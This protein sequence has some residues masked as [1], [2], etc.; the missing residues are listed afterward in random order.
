MN[1]HI[2]HLPAIACRVSVQVQ[3]GLSHSFE[4]WIPDYRDQ[5]ADPLAESTAYVWRVWG[6]MLVQPPYSEP[7]DKTGTVVFR[8]L[9]EP[10][11]VPEILFPEQADLLLPG[12][13]MLPQEVSA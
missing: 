1:N 7:E 2:N 8:K 10:W 6:D 5:V 4:A 9:G 3:P 11:E 12:W 13:A